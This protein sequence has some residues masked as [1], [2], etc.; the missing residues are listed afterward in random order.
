MSTVKPTAGASVIA[1]KR[2]KPA[3]RDMVAKAPP[4]LTAMAQS[5][6]PLN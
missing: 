4:A 5:S 3:F 2:A 1:V 6:L